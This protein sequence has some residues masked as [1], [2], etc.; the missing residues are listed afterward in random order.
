MRWGKNSVRA[1]RGGEVAARGGV[2]Q[3]GLRGIE[4]DCDRIAVREVRVARHR[5]HQVGV[6]GALLVVQRAGV[7][8]RDRHQRLGADVLDQRDAPGQALAAAR[9]RQRLGHRPAP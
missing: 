8:E 5:D 7:D 6:R 9:H 2:E 1:R 3:H 4:A